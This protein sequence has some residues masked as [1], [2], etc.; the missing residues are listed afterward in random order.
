MKK[1]FI[2]NIKNVSNYFVLAGIVTVVAFATEQYSTGFTLGTL[3]VFGCVTG[4]GDQ[5]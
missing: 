1:L 3:V 4:I 2:E 5:S